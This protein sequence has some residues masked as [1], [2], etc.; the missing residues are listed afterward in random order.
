MRLARFKEEKETQL[1]KF[2]YIITIIYIK[3][4]KKGPE[5]GQAPLGPHLGPSLPLHDHYMT[6]QM[7]NQMSY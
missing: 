6:I 1:K 4:K 3:K 2:K 5:W 7:S